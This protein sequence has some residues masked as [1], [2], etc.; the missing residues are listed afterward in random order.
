MINRDFILRQIHQL[1]Q[2]LAQVL[3]NKRL[4]QQTEESREMISMALKDT[5]G[6]DLDRLLLMDRESLMEACSREGGFNAQLAV[7]VAD[8]MKEEGSEAAVQRAYWLYEAA[9][10]H[11]ATLPLQALEWIG[12]QAS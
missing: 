5:L 1:A 7:S 6:N 8:L 11:G 4:D 3:F 12:D 9:L 10:E 2:V